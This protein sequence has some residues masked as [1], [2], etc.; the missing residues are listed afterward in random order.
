MFDLA[1]SLNLLLLIIIIVYILT[2]KV[3]RPHYHQE[4]NKCHCGKL[5]EELHEPPYWHDDD[6]PEHGAFKQ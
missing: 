4:N 3:V 5:G 1:L 2:K 6:C